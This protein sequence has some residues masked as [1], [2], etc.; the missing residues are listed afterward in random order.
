[1]YLFCGTK[2]KKT[3]THTFPSTRT[4][5]HY[6]SLLV[7]ALSFSPARYLPHTL[8][9]SIDQF[10]R[11][12]CVVIGSS[13]LGKTGQQHKLLILAAPPVCLLS[14]DT[15]LNLIYLIANIVHA[16]NPPTNI[17]NKTRLIDTS[18]S[19]PPQFFVIYF[20]NYQEEEK[21]RKFLILA[22]EPECFFC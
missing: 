1:M 5:S 14:I 16:R 19:N 4:F 8:A 21:K 20:Y 18:F 17:L 9:Q 3:R 6:Y 10:G 13:A 2:Q 7:S 12:C 22:V 15:I 11:C